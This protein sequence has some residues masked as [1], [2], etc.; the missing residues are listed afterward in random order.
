[1]Q[2]FTNKTMSIRNLAE[3]EM[4]GEDVGTRGCKE[5]PSCL[6]PFP[7]QLFP[8]GIAGKWD[9]W[10]APP[11]WRFVESFGVS[12]SAWGRV[13]LAVGSEVEGREEHLLACVQER[14][15]GW[16]LI[17]GVWDRPARVEDTSKCHRKGGGR[18]ELTREEH[19]HPNGPWSRHIE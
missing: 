15:W 5:I 9:G 11:H 6:C 3:A 4:R 19:C 17:V 16:G 1:M 2:Q 7:V 14:L 12:W 13:G 18:L 10:E 8:R